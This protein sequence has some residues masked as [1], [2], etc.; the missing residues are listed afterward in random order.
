[1]LAAWD[2]WPLNKD[3]L[4]FGKHLKARLW[5]WLST[6][7]ILCSQLQLLPDLQQLVEAGGVGRVGC[8]Q[9]WDQ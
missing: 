5:P 1:M 6:E 3:L 8:L 7:Q 2:A 4:E 9:S